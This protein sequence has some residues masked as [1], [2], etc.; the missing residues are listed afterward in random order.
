[1]DYA[2]SRAEQC[3]SC[4][5]INARLL[6]MCVTAFYATRGPSGPEIAHLDL[7]DHDML[8]CAMVAILAIRSDYL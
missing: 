6:I 1:M 3:T 8:H 4:D 7:A 5:D 2:R